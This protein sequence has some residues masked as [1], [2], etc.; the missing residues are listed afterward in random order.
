MSSWSSDWGTV[1]YYTWKFFQAFSIFRA[2][3]YSVWPHSVAAVT[4]WNSFFCIEV[5][6][7]IS[8]KLEPDTRPT[9]ECMTEW[10]NFVLMSASDVHFTKSFMEQLSNNCALLSRSM[11]IKMDLIHHTRSSILLKS[12]TFETCKENFHNTHIA[13]KLRLQKIKSHS[14]KHLLPLTKL[15]QTL[16]SREHINQ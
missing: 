4:D 12:S 7:D 9:V 10:I 16:M 11:N 2:W 5:V 1:T 13:H 6:Q 3:G 8:K 15:V 14:V